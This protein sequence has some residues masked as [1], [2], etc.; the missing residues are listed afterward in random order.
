MLYIATSLLQREKLDVIRSNIGHGLALRSALS[1]VALLLQFLF[2]PLPTNSS[3]DHPS[4]YNDPK[5]NANTK[6]ISFFYLFDWLSQ[7][8]YLYWFVVAYSRFITL[9][10]GH[11][12]EGTLICGQTEWATTQRQKYRRQHITG[13]QKILWTYRNTQPSLTKC[14]TRLAY[15]LWN[16]SFTYSPTF[17]S[18]PCLP[19]AKHLAPTMS[20][21]PS[22]LSVY[23]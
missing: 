18:S 23:D 14:P 2:P 10:A 12:V 21:I 9:W 5:F 17:P 15:Y 20:P 6:G 8:L 13:S 3:L 4:Q 7:S 1:I 19:S 16:S 11:V 22:V